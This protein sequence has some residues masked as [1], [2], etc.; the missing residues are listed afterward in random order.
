MVIVG[1]NDLIEMKSGS[2]TGAHIGQFRQLKK[3]IDWNYF[4]NTK[5]SNKPNVKKFHMIPESLS[6]MEPTIE[7]QF[8]LNHLRITLYGGSDL[9]FAILP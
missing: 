4:T 2:I 8:I 7:I 5:K 9:D 6:K 1:V 3:L